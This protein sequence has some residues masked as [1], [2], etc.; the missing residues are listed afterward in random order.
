MLYINKIIFIIIC[1]FCEI[2]ANIEKC[3]FV[4]KAPFTTN[5]DFI[6]FAKSYKEVEETIKRGF[7]DKKIGNNKITYLMVQPCIFN[8]KEY[9]V[10]CFDSNPIFISYMCSNKRSKDGINKAFITKENEKNLL[11]FC[12]EAIL[13]FKQRCPYVFQL[14][15]GHFVVN[16]FESL[17]A[18]Y[19]SSNMKADK[20][21]FSI[22]QLLENYWYKKLRTLFDE[23]YT[24]MIVKEKQNVS[25]DELLKT[26]NRVSSQLN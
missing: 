6:R 12:N 10:V 16:E 19:Y 18:N 8:R 14:C 21:E 20:E 1:S 23:N 9:K 24:T 17:E 4:V 2:H 7:V 15:S 22:T 5:S 26:F 25:I 3:G 13:E 11:R